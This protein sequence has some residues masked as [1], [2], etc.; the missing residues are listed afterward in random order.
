M[1]LFFNLVLLIFVALASEASASTIQQWTFTSDS[2]GWTHGGSYLWWWEAAVGN[3]PGCLGNNACANDGGYSTWYTSYAIPSAGGQL[4]LSFDAGAARVKWGPTYITDG[5]LMVQITN[6]SGTYTLFNEI[7]ASSWT[8]RT[9]D[10]SQFKGQTVTITF[11]NYGGGT[12]GGD[13]DCD[14]EHVFIDNIKIS[15]ATPDQTTTSPIQQLSTTDT[16]VSWL[17][18]VTVAGSGVCSYSIPHVDFVGGSVEVRDKLNAFIAFSLNGSLVEWSCSDASSPYSVYWRTP[19]AT[20][21]VVWSQD[22]SF[23]SNLTQQYL[24]GTITVTNPSAENYVGLNY[25][26]SAPS[27]FTPLPAS[28]SFNVSAGSSASA[29][30]FASGN[31][32]AAS[33]GSDFTQSSA[34]PTTA[35]GLA[36]TEKS[37]SASNAAGVA[38]SNVTVNSSNELRSGWNCSAPS[39]IAV[40]AGGYSNASFVQCSKQGVITLNEGGWRTNTSLSNT[41]A[42]QHLWET[43]S[44]TNADSVAYANVRASVAS[45]A[46]NLAAKSNEVVSWIDISVA[47]GGSWSKT[48]SVDSDWL[49]ESSSS[50]RTGSTEKTTLTVGN[51]AS[52]LFDGVKASVSFDDSFVSTA[53]FLR[54]QYGS[55]QDITPSSN[56]PT[57]SSLTVSGEVWTSCRI[58]ADGDGKADGFEFVFPHFSTWSV[59]GGGSQGSAQENNQQNELTQGRSNSSASPTPTPNPSATSSPSGNESGSLDGIDIRVPSEIA[60]GYQTVYVFD[61]GS[62][63]SGDVEIIG[64]DGKSVWR[65]LASDGAFGFFFDREGEWTIRYGNHSKKIKVVREREPLPSVAQ[66]GSSNDSL[67]GG[68]TG[69]AVGGV[70]P[71]WMA[72][73]LLLV[74]A[75]VLSWYFLVYTTLHVEKKFSGETITLKVVNR[76]AE[77]RELEL[78]D[79]APEEY[80]AREFSEPPEL[81]ETVLGTSLKWK[82]E[83]LLK[84]GEWIVSYKLPGAKG[85]LKHASVV[86]RTA[87]GK[88]VKAAS[89]EVSL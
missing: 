84:G 75:A 14:Y 19:A 79:V 20:A 51:T 89:D 80:G 13:A 85:K 45:P 69:F 5:G 39:N 87:K 48:A 11:V 74:L 76:N 7:I 10:L 46:G 63:A 47:A 67:I 50:S 28:L 61:A 26:V 22:S 53:L 49:N 38:L 70:D 86:G 15:N 78:T 30:V 88:D 56:C 68:A 83:N 3:P 73:L 17:S 9:T 82:R 59:E 16:L 12:L 25:L 1:K 81:G 31:G 54:V 35:G 52:A 72:L 32:L 23:E 29:G 60:P 27:G 58:D 66:L 37:L 41:L 57:Q 18:S 40:A 42:L 71:L 8:T 43:V 36:W 34:N 55:W 24:V 65:T 64:P 21:S 2:Q 44:G 33:W 6:G 4:N 77:L 62:P